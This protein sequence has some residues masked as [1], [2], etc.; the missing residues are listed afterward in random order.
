MGGGGGGL[1]PLS[2]TVNTI[3]VHTEGFYQHPMQ[4]MSVRGG[5]G[6][7]RPLSLTHCHL[8]L[9]SELFQGPMQTCNVC[10]STRGAS[11]VNATLSHMWLYPWGY[12]EVLPVSMS[13]C[14]HSELYQFHMWLY[15]WG[16]WEVLPLS[17][18]HVFTLEWILSTPHI[19]NVC[20]SAGW[21]QFISYWYPYSH[22]P[23]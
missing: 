9:H 16:Y 10:K 12:W 11:C 7:V 13:P 3:C 8:C 6:G 15:L 1:L 22:S 23:M 2:L 19:A 4:L 21:C 20:G 18:T 17:L 5:G 14:W